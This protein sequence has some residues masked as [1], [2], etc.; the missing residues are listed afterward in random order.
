MPSLIEIEHSDWI[1][2]GPALEG[3]A[4]LATNT[5]RLNRMCTLAIMEP[6]RVSN[7]YKA[8]NAQLICLASYEY[9]QPANTLRV[10]CLHSEYMP[11]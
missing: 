2:K 7:E 11:L 9:P 4:A 5:R 8:E 6:A 3:M 10:R 1:V